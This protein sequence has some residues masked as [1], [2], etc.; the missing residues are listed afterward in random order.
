MPLAMPGPEKILPL[1]PPNAPEPLFTQSGPLG[2]KNWF[3]MSGFFSLHPISAATAI[4][5]IRFFTSLP[6][7]WAVAK[8]PAALFVRALET[9]AFLRHQRRRQVVPRVQPGLRRSVARRRLGS[10]PITPGKLLRGRDHRA[11]AGVQYTDVQRGRS[12][13]EREHGPARRRL[14]ARDDHPRNAIRASGRLGC[15]LVEARAHLGAE[16]LGRE[17]LCERAR[18]LLGRE[19]DGP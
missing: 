10:A 2:C 16:P 1:S 6:P 12:G 8:R 14:R 11:G 9:A 19:Q 18:N 13:H 15:L 4:S 3:D 5:P 17:R 7:S